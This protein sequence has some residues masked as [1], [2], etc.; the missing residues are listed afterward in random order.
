MRVGMDTIKKR[1]FLRRYRRA[2]ISSIVLVAVAVSSFEFREYVEDDT[3]RVSR[4]YLVFQPVKSEVLI[5]QMLLR[6]NA[7]PKDIIYVDAAEG[8]NVKQILINP[9]DNVKKSDPLLLLTNTQLELQVLEQESR[10]IESMNQLQN[11]QT[12][13]EQTRLSNETAESD[14]QYNID[15]LRVLSGR[16]QRLVEQGFVS[17]SSL[18]D[19]RLELESYIRKLDLQKR[20]NAQFSLYRKKQLPQLK[21]QLETLEENLKITRGKLDSLTVRAPF[22]G[23]VTSMDLKV[24]QTLQ[25][26]ERLAQITL[27]TGFKLSQAVDEYY[28]PKIKIGQLGIVKADDS[29]WNVEVKR[30]YPQVKNGTFLVDFDFSGE[31]PTGLF[32]GQTIIGT[33]NFDDGTESTSL[34]IPGG[35]YLEKTGGQ[36][37]FVLSDDG[38]SARRRQIKTGQHSL[39]RVEVISGLQFGEKIVVSDYG[40]FGKNQKILIDN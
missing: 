13:L 1:G 19:Q 35:S 31:A 26:G 40:D 22:S 16:N 21:I 28:L 29:E 17:T 5:D 18:M 34:T 2:I 37:V 36:W 12:S 9:G 11:A 3:V 10:L 14:I 8:G 15:R 6:L 32:L 4:S 27:D 24:G 38:K 23:L 25:K 39:D 20:G 33:L 30:I 7:S